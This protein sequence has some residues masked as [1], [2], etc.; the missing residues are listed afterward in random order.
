MLGRIAP[1]L[2]IPFVEN[3]FK[4]GISLK[5]KSWIKIKLECHDNILNFEVRNSIHKNESNLEHEK[6][7]IGLANVKER[8]KLQYPD[9]NT[10][11]ILHTENEYSIKLIVQ[12]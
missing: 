7:G 2:L 6:S 11:D 8:L 9:K 5:E 12:C 4:H 3:A 1:M 10:L